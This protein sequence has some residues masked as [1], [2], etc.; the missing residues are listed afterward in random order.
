MAMADWVVQS[1]VYD[2]NPEAVSV[3][4]TSKES[5]DDLKYSQ[6]SVCGQLFKDCLWIIVIVAAV[7]NSVSVVLIVTKLDDLSEM[8]DV[9][10][11]G[12]VE[13]QFCYE[14]QGEITGG[15]SC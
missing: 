3:A 11:Y 2:A 4:E 10:Y 15:R 12:Q 13:K 9:M 8:A 1:S 14:K 5:D 7:T 6:K